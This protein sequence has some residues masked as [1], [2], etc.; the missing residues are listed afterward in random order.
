MLT[1]ATKGSL[2]LSHGKQALNLHGRREKAFSPPSPLHGRHEKA[3]FPPSPVH[4][5]CEKAF[6]P[7]SPVHGRRE[8]AFSPPSPLALL[9]PLP[10]H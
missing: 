6:S 2:P 3:F 1:L 9:L 10:P 7:P 8:K 4:G 5:R